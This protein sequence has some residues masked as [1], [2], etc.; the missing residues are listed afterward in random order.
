MIH[1][2]LNDIH[3]AANRFHRRSSRTDRMRSPVT[4][5]CRSQRTFDA[6]CA[7]GLGAWKMY[8]QRSLMPT[9]KLPTVSPG[10]EDTVK[11]LNSL[12]SNAAYINARK[13]NATT[14]NTT[15]Q[16]TEKYLIRSGLSLEQ[17]ESLSVIHVAGTKG[18][19]SCCAFVEAI[20]RE[21][22][23][24][25]GFYSSPHLVSVRE[26]IRINGQPI[27]EL[28]FSRHFWHVFGTLDRL[29]DDEQD[30]PQYFKFLTIL[31]FHMFVK[32]NVDVAILE[33]GIGGEHDCTNIVT[34]TV[35]AG[36]TSLALDHTSLL[37]DTI[38]A[39]AY[40][41]SGI[42]KPGALAF[43]VIQSREAMDV[44]LSRARERNCTLSQVPSLD[45]YPWRKSVPTLGIR[46]DVQKENASL[47]IQLASTWLAR[48]GR[49]GR[50]LSVLGS[51]E[52]KIG[53]RLNGKYVATDETPQKKSSL[54]FA[55]V[56]TALESCKWPGRTQYLPGRTI[57]FYVDGAHTEES[58]EC[59]V[60]WFQSIV[61]DP[62]RNR[63]YLMF[64]S[65]GDRDSAKLLAPLKCL[66]F[67]KAF[68]VPNV[69]GHLASVDQENYNM[70]I[71]KQM[72]KCRFHAEFWGDDSVLSNS[73]FD[74]LMQI[75]NDDQV[76]K[77]SAESYKPQLLVTGSLH[78]VGALLS[79]VDPELIMST[80]F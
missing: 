43:T 48:H 66:G 4:T 32:A 1:V 20:L 61:K 26:R 30:M 21:H 24:R 55:K 13:R 27:G 58:I 75:R 67:R 53:T 40:Q 28:D 39:I 22:G 47:A 35:C 18:K 77:T 7:L 51:A 10:Y 64:N 8:S 37:G 71:T 54:C 19:G 46:S 17:L 80:N 34:N 62:R 72:E 50:R 70:P 23:F 2:C 68:F 57:D 29:K 45:S 69:A 25:T 33:V 63:R 3:I 6:L 41:K 74:A 31:M 56:A 9:T 78:L 11:S 49:N 38:E 16:D 52:N 73:V 14:P 76:H 60:T 65:T 79:I 15:L 59:C 42:F 12:Q 36:V 5:C 44:L